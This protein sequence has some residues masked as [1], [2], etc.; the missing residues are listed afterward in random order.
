MKFILVI[1]SILCFNFGFS[2]EKTVK[3]YTL[4]ELKN[5]SIDSVY[6]IDLKKLDLYE[7]PKEIFQFKHLQYLNLSKNKLQN[8]NGL[9]HFPQLRYLN[10]E[11][12]KLQYF[13]VSI[14]QLTQLETLIVNRNDFESIPSCIQYCQQL[15]TIDLFSTAV[16]S[17]PEEMTRIKTIELID[18][19]GVQIN[20]SRQEQLRN[21]FPNAKLVLD[22]PCNCTH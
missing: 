11:R 15:K 21:M 13:P 22:P 18:F 16:T 2:Q 7:L 6:A 4:E 20:K 14:C 5:A 12:N 8:T 9:E 19:S 3:F 10:L 1:T 17:L